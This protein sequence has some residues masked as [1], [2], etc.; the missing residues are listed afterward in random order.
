LEKSNTSLINM[1]RSNI[2]EQEMLE[3]LNTIFENDIPSS[4]DM[5]DVKNVYSEIHKQHVENVKFYLDEK[6]S[7]NWKHDFVKAKKLA[8][9]QDFD[10][11]LNNLPLD[12]ELFA[13][14][15]F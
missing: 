7:S 15:G 11:Y 2:T 14:V 12:C 1:T 9:N 5:S 4:Y 3:E 10:T 8:A 6:T 13:V